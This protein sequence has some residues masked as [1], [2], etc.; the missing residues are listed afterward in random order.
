MY[1]LPVCM[2]R[3][4]S[5]RYENASSTSPNLPLL[6]E[7]GAGEVAC[8]RVS[9]CAPPSQLIPLLRHEAGAGSP[10]NLYGGGS[11]LVSCGSPRVQRDSF[12]PPTIHSF[13]GSLTETGYPAAGFPRTAVPQRH[14]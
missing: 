9:P 14:R 13:Q 12:S 7:E 5:M 3:A 1:L 8:T 2:I 4:E 10:A 11:W 6:G